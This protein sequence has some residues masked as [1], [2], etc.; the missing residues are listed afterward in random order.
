LPSVRQGIRNLV[1]IQSTL[2]TLGQRIYRLEL[3][4]LVGDGP[5]SRPL[6][7]FRE[8]LIARDENL[9]RLRAAVGDYNDVEL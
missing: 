5:W 6:A 4:L 7:A 3:P 2:G 8:T 9:A 1:F